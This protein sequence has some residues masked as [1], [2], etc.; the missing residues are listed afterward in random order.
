MTEHN[1]FAKRFANG[2]D[3][4]GDECYNLWVSAYH[5]EENTSKFINLK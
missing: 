2:Y 1:L 5:P 3:L 4:K